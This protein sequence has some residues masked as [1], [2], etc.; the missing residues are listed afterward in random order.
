MV[1]VLWVL[2]RHNITALCRTQQQRLHEDMNVRRTRL[3]ILSPHIYLISTT[4]QMLMV[5]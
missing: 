3:T 4:E 1:K 2:C 5:N